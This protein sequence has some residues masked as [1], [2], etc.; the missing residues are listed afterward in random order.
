MASTTPVLS[1]RSFFCLLYRCCFEREKTVWLTGDIFCII[2]WRRLWGRS[3]SHITASRT[4]ICMVLT[5]TMVTTDDVQEEEPPT[6]A[7]EK[8]VKTLAAIV[9][10]L[11]KQNRDLEE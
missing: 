8:K 2:S 10:R 4:K 3:V 1:A 7:L 11:T 5:R 6:T 9:E